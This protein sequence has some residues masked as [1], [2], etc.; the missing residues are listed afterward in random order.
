MSRS[1]GPGY[2]SSTGTLISDI[3]DRS[4]LMAETMTAADCALPSPLA[5]GPS[6][7]RCRP[8]AEE[9]D[10]RAERARPEAVR[11][12]AVGGVGRVVGRE[13]LGLVGPDDL[14]GAVVEDVDGDHA[15][16]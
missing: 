11:R 15:A 12:V 9:L 16:P 14:A 10:G 3:L 5:R 13:D 4:T 1:V 2:T 7:S 8:I 6:T